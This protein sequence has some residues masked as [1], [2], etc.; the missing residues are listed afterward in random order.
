MRLIMVAPSLVKA[1]LMEDLAQYV[2]DAVRTPALEAADGVLAV[3]NAWR[4]TRIR[5]DPVKVSSWASSPYDAALFGYYVK[6]RGRHLLLAAI[7]HGDF[8]EFVT[9]EPRTPDDMRKILG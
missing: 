1:N 5:E 7:D 4:G 8:I 3:F 2:T 9:R 6:Q